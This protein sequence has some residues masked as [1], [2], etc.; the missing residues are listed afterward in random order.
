MKN[1]AKVEGSIV[2]QYINEEISTF[3]SYYF[4]S[5]IKTKTRRGDRHYDGGN[6]E[7]TYMVEAIPDIFSQPGRRSGKEK[8][9]WLRDEDYHIAHTYVLRNC[10]Q[11]RPFERYEKLIYTYIF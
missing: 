5:H 2:E 6:Q 1:K 11:L 7:D 9:T 4:E 8:E 3:C 10:D